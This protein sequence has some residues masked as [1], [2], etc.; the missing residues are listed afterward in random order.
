MSGAGARE[1]LHD[2][3][4]L[5]EIELVGNL[6]LAASAAPTRRLTPDEIDEALGLPPRA[7]RS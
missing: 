4:M 3:E 6:V 1:D 5:E 2:M 7:L